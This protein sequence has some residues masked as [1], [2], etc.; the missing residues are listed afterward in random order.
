MKTLSRKAGRPLSF[1]RSAALRAA[2]L[3]FWRHGYE[4]TSIVDLTTAMGITAPSLYAA[5]GDKQQ[6]FLE[7]VAL[8]IGDPAEVARAI[9]EAISAFQAASDLLEAVAI[10]YT[11]EETPSGCLLASATATGSAGACDVRRVVA[12]IRRDLATQLARRIDR[13]IADGLLPADCDANGLADLV[14]AVTQGMSAL[15]RDGG[16]RAQLL[17]VAHTAMKAWPERPQPSKPTSAASAS[18]EPGG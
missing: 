17:A 15:A 6:L 10:T 18:T 3:A 12:G 4:T 13:D 1:D 2:M 8:Y 5:F 7:A 11:G 14:V 16:T 9:D